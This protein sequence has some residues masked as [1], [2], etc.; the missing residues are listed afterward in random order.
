MEGHSKK[1]EA[2]EQMKADSDSLKVIS[3]VSH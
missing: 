2:T 3:I 1:N